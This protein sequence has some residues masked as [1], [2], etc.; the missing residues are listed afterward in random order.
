ML[1]LHITSQ[2]IWRSTQYR[3]INDYFASS[4]PLS[5]TIVVLEEDSLS[6]YS[7]QIIS[8]NVEV[9]DSVALKL[10]SIKLE[11]AICNMNIDI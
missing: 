5:A 7:M 10:D 4:G 2:I 3:G 8:L 9:Q 11:A 6:D 1:I